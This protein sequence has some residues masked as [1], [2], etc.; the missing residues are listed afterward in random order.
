MR[1][2]W[3]AR[4]MITFPDAQSGTTRSPTCDLLIASL[5]ISMMMMMMMMMKRKFV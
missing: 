2:Q 5:T 1:G 3:D 4:P